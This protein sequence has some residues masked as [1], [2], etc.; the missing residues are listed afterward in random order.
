MA[1]PRSLRNSPLIILSA[2]S[3]ASAAWLT[4]RSWYCQPGNTIC[5]TNQKWPCRGSV[6]VNQKRG[7]SQTTR[8]AVER[9]AVVARIVLVPL[10]TEFSPDEA[11]EDSILGEKGGINLLGR[12]DWNQAAA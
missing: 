6:F 8:M 10:G 5:S 12:P 3:T 4:G 2:A 11:E 9:R 1:A 7:N